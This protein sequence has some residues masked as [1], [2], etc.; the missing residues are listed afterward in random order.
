MLN[1]SINWRL[2]LTIMFLF[3]LT[4]ALIKC[5]GEGRNFDHQFEFIKK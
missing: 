2:W 5:A 4:P 3:G 1:M